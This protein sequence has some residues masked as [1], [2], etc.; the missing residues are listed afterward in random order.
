VS[1]SNFTQE[2]LKSNIA[3]LL[4]KSAQ[5]PIQGNGADLESAAKIV[6][7]AEFAMKK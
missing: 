2:F 4:S 3:D 6:A 7:L 1:Q 5:A